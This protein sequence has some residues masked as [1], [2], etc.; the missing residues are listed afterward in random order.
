MARRTVR[1]DLKPIF[2]F[3]DGQ[4]IA[5]ASSAY[6]NKIWFV[7]LASKWQQERCDALNRFVQRL[8]SR[9]LQHRGLLRQLARALK[10]VPKFRTDREE[11]LR[12]KR[13]SL[14]L[15]KQNRKALAAIDKA[16]PK[17][18]L[19]GATKTIGFKSPGNK[20]LWGTRRKRRP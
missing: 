3:R 5:W 9:D 13:E 15:S 14:E 12:Q 8:F 4:V 2:A 17:G 18:R 10:E 19:I 11:E 16:H 1:T 6:E 20:K 7:R